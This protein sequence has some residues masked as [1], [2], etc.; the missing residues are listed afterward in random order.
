M[1][2]L[3]MM[4]KSANIPMN[5]QYDVLIAQLWVHHIMRLVNEGKSADDMRKAVCVHDQLGKLAISLAIKITLSAPH[6]IIRML[7]ASM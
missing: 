2:E 7:L 1:M 4:C 6:H 3:D 5:K